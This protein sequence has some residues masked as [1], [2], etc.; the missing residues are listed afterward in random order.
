MSPRLRKLVATALLL[1]G[2]VAYALGAMVLADHVP[3]HW[4]AKLVYF[5]VAGIAWA[6]P[7]RALLRWAE[8][9]L[10]SPKTG[11]ETRP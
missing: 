3:A 5:I 6:F 1:P 4:L 10:L 11:A 2:L 7:A 8:G 9:P